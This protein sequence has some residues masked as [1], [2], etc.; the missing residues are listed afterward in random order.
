MAYLLDTHALIWA[1]AEPSRFA[2]AVLAILQD[3]RNPLFFSA[4]SIW[5]IAIKTALNK[6]HFN[7][8]AREMAVALKR[9]GYLEL[10]I[11]AHHAAGIAALPPMHQDP[12]DRL[13][14]AQARAEGLVLV[15]NDG[16]IIR[17]CDGY[18]DLVPCT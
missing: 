16:N 14:V 10:P 9:V 2:P 4:A 3:E 11:S 18:I 13:L 12:F 5:E 6:P 17:Y 1:A 8:N 15:T 7:I